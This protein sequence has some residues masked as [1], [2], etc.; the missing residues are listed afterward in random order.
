MKKKIWI[1]PLVIFIL[2]FLIMIIEAVTLYDDFD[3][4]NLDL[5]KWRTLNQTDG[6][7]I[8]FAEA[9]QRIQMGVELTG[10]SQTARV[11]LTSISNYVSP[12]NWTASDII[13]GAFGGADKWAYC[14]VE[15]GGVPVVELNRSLVT[16]GNYT[17]SNWTVYTSGGNTIIANI[18]GTQ[19]TMTGII[20]SGVVS[21]RC[22]AES[23][24]AGGA[25]LQN[26][27]IDTV[28]LEPGF[29]ILLNHPS[30]GQTTRN[31]TVLFNASIT[32]NTT[33]K[34]ATLSL[35][36]NNKSLY[37]QS[38]NLL[39]G[40]SNLTKW[41][42]GFSTVNNYI[43]NVYSCHTDNTCGNTSNRTMFWGLQ[44][45]NQSIFNATGNELFN[46]QFNITLNSSSTPTV[47][48]VYNGTSYT[49]TLSSNG[50]IHNA[51][52]TLTLSSSNVGRKSVV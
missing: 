24:G 9:N 29:S 22:M 7:Q 5:N 51:V 50:N 43:W 28:Y 49:S 4:N 3:D 32:G 44:D 18:A 47:T 14:N 30:N 23:G 12:L 33:L 35:W 1:S 19:R 41:S 37:N 31:S 42:H 40:T 8:S 20:V 48:F 45:V 2:F 52:R 36:Y 11:N 13:G 15:V 21:F 10:A 34:N 38:T 17:N 27:T 25:A 6:G 46:E 16:Y 39:N 26:Q